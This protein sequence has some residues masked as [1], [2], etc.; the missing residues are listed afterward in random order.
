MQKYLAF[1][2][3]AYIIGALPT[4]AFFARLKKGKSLIEP[5]TRS[6]KRPQDVFEILGIPLGI[7]VSILDILKGILVVRFLTTVFFGQAGLQ[8]WWIAAIGGLLVVIGHCNSALLGF[9]GGRGLAPTFGVLV[10]IFPIPAILSTLLGTWLAFWGLSSK[11]GALSA[12]GVMPILSIVW[13]T[14]FRPEETY[15]LFVV[16]FMSLWTMWEYRDELNNY[17][18][19]S[20][21]N[22]NIPP[23]TS[24][25]EDEIEQS[26][27][28]EQ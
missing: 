18:G 2:L 16:A 25:Q 9:R 22:K 8:T 24:P 5:G 19:L 26:E 17:L 3:L 7:F 28:I 27:N 1:A 23:P 6:T 11:P 4:G 15:Y 12:A 14:W 21:A 20:S 10:S 13:V